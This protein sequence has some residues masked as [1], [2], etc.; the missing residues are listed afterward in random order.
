LNGAPAGAQAATIEGAGM[1]GDKLVEGAQNPSLIIEKA[2][3]S[4]IQVGKPATFEIRVKNIGKSPAH[5]VTITDQVPRGTKFVE[6][7]PDCQRG[8][9][10]VLTWQIETLR[11]GEERVLTL[12]LMPVAEG[13]IGS[14]AQVTF[15]AHAGTRTICTRPVLQ[16]EHTAPK[17]VLIGET[18]RLGITLINS[19]SGA[20]TGVSIEEDVPEGLSHA[21]GRELEYE[22]GTL[23]P[24][25]TKQLELI[26]VADKPGTIENV[27][28][29]R[30]EGNLVTEHRASIEVI[31]PQLQVGVTGPKRRYLDRQATYTVSVANPGTASAREVE[32]MATL[33]KGMKFV[34]ADG[35]GQ[36]DPRQHA[37]FW[38]LEELPPSKAGSVTLTT[39]PTEPGEQRL[40]V[41]GKAELGLTNSG[42]QIVQVVTAAVLF[43]SIAIL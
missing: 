24:G 37:V 19:G 21:A 18:V 10:G 31:A 29:A 11:P 30:G 27:V 2:A 28:I 17:R 3:P 39:V 7:R 12:Q 8:G 36:Y 22:V 5:Q 9:D 41:E 25:E 40:L 16:V 23:K 26:L 15:L 33:P 38:S 1:P 14:V 34:S 6:A 20:A 42:E 4:E 32:L 35:E 13:E 43:F